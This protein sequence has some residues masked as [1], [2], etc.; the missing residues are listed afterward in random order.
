L[1]DDEKLNFNSRVELK[2]EKG[3]VINLNDNPANDSIFIYNN[4][5]EHIL[6]TG[7]GSNDHAPRN[8]QISGKG[9]ISNQTANGDYKI[10]VTDGREINIHNNSTGAYKPQGEGSE[11]YGNINVKSENKDINI[12]ARGDESSLF[13]IT[14]KARIQIDDNGDIRIHANQGDINI[15]SPDGNINIKGVNLNMDFE[16]INIKASNNIAVHASNVASIKGDAQA[17]IDGGQVHLN[18]GNSASV[19]PIDGG[20]F[21]Y[22]N[23]L[24]GD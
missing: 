24:Y 19:N 22:Q 21:E 14:P 23:T 10:T 6:I 5:T 11:K 2:S 16:Q 20:V 7:D 13:I 15:D 17:A 4:L 9:T 3:K 8:I 1:K 12:V 18:S